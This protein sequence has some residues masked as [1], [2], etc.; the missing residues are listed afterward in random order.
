MH[1]VE[2]LSQALQKKDAIPHFRKALILHP[3]LEFNNSFID[4]KTGDGKN[5]F[6]TFLAVQ[7]EV[8]DNERVSGKVPE[9]YGQAKLYIDGVQRSYQDDKVPAGD[10]FIQIQ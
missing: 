2:A 8:I 4:H 9:K 6:E 5:L 10:H 1:F 7:A 3:R